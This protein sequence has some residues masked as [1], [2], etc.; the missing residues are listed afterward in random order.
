MTDA[1]IDHKPD[2][3][4]IV[5]QRA[6]MHDIREMLALLPK[7]IE[8][9]EAEGRRLEQREAEL[10][11]AVRRGASPDPEEVASVA[12]AQAALVQRLNVLNARIQTMTK[13]AEALVQAADT[14][15]F[16]ALSRQF[17]AQFNLQEGL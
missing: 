9:A 1:N 2:P 11:E 5:R 17:S 14:C 8:T 4:W 7:A 6:V 10:G 16:E 3:E 13:Q 15:Q 12:A